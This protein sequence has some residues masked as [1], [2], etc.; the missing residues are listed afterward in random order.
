M[1]ILMII[2]MSTV[3]EVAQQAVDS[4][5]DAVIR[6]G[7]TIALP[8]LN[9][10]F[11]YVLGK[12]KK[13]IYQAEISDQ[14]TLERDKQITRVERLV[15]HLL[16]IQAKMLLTSKTTPELK[17]A[18]ATEIY[19]ALQEAQL[20]PDT[21]LKNLLSKILS[22]PSLDADKIEEEIDNDL[23]QKLSELDELDVDQ[24]YENL[25]SKTDTQ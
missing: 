25:Q 23:E 14:L 1:H 15:I 10:L 18:I 20:N 11:L 12:L 5:W 7:Y 16:Q 6:W 24:A 2:L 19:T 13:K 22:G 17:N 21:L 9:V 8:L 3:D 4:N